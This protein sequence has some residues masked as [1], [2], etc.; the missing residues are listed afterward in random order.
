ML[1]SC[2]HC[3][4]D[5]SD[6]GEFLTSIELATNRYN[7]EDFEKN[8]LRLYTR[9]SDPIENQ[10][11]VNKHFRDLNAQVLTCRDCSVPCNGRE[12]RHKIA[13]NITIPADRVRE[14]VDRLFAD[15]FITSGLRSDLEVPIQ[16]LET[17]SDLHAKIDNE[18]AHVTYGQKCVLQSSVV[19]EAGVLQEK[20]QPWQIRSALEL[21]KLIIEVSVHADTEFNHIITSSRLYP[22]VGDGLSPSFSTPV[23][24]ESWSPSE[25]K[26]V[27]DALKVVGRVMAGR[28][29]L[30]SELLQLGPS[31]PSLEVQEQVIMELF[32]TGLFV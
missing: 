8:C 25:K 5:I 19:V 24:D 20:F 13:R 2:S 14:A 3:K 12:Q 29:N 22:S 30:E 10:A 7:A 1:V 16:E 11:F 6:Q 21:S 15:S 9:S 26:D 18:I 31:L 4:Y 27:L 28:A 32:P 17:C 23:I